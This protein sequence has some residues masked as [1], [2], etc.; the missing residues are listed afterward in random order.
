VIGSL[1]EAKI[2]MVAQGEADKTIFTP[3]VHSNKRNVAANN[4]SQGKVIGKR[5]SR[6]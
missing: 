3:Q 4:N 6:N 1:E 5:Y 2:A